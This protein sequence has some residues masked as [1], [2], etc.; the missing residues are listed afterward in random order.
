MGRKKLYDSR[1]NVSLSPGLREAIDIQVEQRNKV[2]RQKV[3]AADIIRGILETHLGP[4]T[5][6]DTID[7]DIP[8][9][10]M[11]TLGC[12]RPAETFEDEQYFCSKC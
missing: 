5:G 8:E 10:Q 6:N 3:S 12:G 1:I 11:C 4:V 9:G 7:V 2:S